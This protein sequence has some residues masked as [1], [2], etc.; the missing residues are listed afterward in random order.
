[1]TGVFLIAWLLLQV[2]TSP[3]LNRPFLGTSV[4][5]QVLLMKIF[6]FSPLNWV[7]KFLLSI[8]GL[9]IS[10]LLEKAAWIQFLFYQ[11]EQ[12]LVWCSYASQIHL[13]KILMKY[14]HTESEWW[15]FTGQKCEVT[16]TNK[17][18]VIVSQRKL[19]HEICFQTQLQVL[20]SLATTCWLRKWKRTTG[21]ATGNMTPDT[22]LLP[23][24]RLCCCVTQ[25]SE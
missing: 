7:G 23:T 4:L 22:C 16:E 20:F 21:L 1:M 18:K 3:W 24:Q 12:M 19:S 6:F 9:F 13:I 14:Y 17:M 5:L 15:S 11:G 8:D 25:G 10:I 2:Y